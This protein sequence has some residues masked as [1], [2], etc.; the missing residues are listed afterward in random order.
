MAK[1]TVMSI[2]PDGKG[3]LRYS[4]LWK[5]GVRGDFVKLDYYFLTCCTLSIY[6]LNECYCTVIE[7]LSSIEDNFS[8]TFNK[9]H[10]VI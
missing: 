1:E 6:I 2:H 3:G 9:L 4:P 8:D 5:R 10:K 7:L